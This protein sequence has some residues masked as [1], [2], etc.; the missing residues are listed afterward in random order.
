LELERLE[1]ERI[2]EEKRKKRGRGIVKKKNKKEEEEAARLAEEKKKGEEEKKKEV[3]FLDP[4]NLE[5][6]I[7]T[8]K[9]C[10]EKTA[11]LI[12]VLVTYDKPRA[13]NSQIHSV[14]FFEEFLLNVLFLEFQFFIKIF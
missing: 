5:D 12:I 1:K 6:I 13:K 11:K 3:P 9:L 14:K 7:E 10:L 4:D 2:E 8:L